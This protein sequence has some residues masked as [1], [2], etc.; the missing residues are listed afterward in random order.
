MDEAELLAWYG[1]WTRRAPRDI[2]ALFEGY[3]GSWWVAGGWAIQAF[4]GV[5]RAHGDIDPSALAAE[6][7]ALRR[8]LSAQGYH[9]WCAVGGALHPLLPEASPDGGPEVLPAG[10]GQL[11][12]RRDAQSPWEYDLLLSPGTPEEW[13]YK[14]DD[15]IRVPVTDALWE[16]DGVRYLQPHL[17]LLLKAPGDRPKDRADLAACLPRLSGAQ[18]RWLRDALALAHP[19]HPWLEQVTA[20]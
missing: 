16:R 7:P 1:D 19:D 2:A 13:V 18:R 3:G 6:L 9:A 15:R 17:Q 11:W 10:C 4:S 20:G 14:R 12:L 5:E 8:H